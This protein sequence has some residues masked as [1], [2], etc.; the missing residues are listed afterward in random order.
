M[1]GVKVVGRNGATRA[2]M[3]DI[4][5][6]AG[7]S[8]A[9]VS[10]VLNG[11]PDVSAATRALVLEHIRA[12]GYVSNRIAR[13]S[14][15]TG[16][17]GLSAPYVRGEY[18]TEIVTGAM[19]ALYERDARLVICSAEPNAEA[20]AS[21]PERLMQGV[22]DGALL[23]LPS[24][25]GAELSALR[26]SGY[27]FVVIDP[28]LPLDEEIPVVAAANWSGA[29]LATEHL[30]GLGHT[31]IGIIT[32]PAGSVASAERLAGYQAALIAAGLPLVHKLTQESALTMSG[33]EQAA[34]ALLAQQ[35]APTAILALNDSMAI[36]VL[37]A[38]HEQ[39]LHVPHDLSIVGFGDVEMA[40]VVTPPL[41]TVRQPLRGMGRVGVEVLHRL[42]NGQQLDAMRIELSTRLVVRESTA[43]PRGTSF[44]TY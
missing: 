35:H 42:L 4:A 10:R 43:P 28:V 30:I 14:W 33:G 12:S 16:L 7:V 27:P 15:E 17:V 29:R 8:I 25:S 36:G 13:A 32:G 34:R 20:E 2:A 23:I 39:G 37:R 9:T 41:T 5:E 26:Q 38:A 6:R 1:T 21:L 11:R 44:L 22:T 31:H 3:R 24:E 19:E 18:V 40:S